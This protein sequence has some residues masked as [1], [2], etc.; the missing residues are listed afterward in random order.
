MLEQYLVV[1]LCASCASAL[2]FFS[3]FG[4]GTLLLPIFALFFPIEVAIA[5]TG[6]VHLLNNLF[7]L[8]L[9][10]RSAV[11]SVV[12]L[13]GL[14]AIAA[15]FGGALLMARLSGLASLFRYTIG[16]TEFVVTPLGLLVGVLM[17]CFALFELNSTAVRAGGGRALLPIGGVLSGFFGGLSGHQGAFRSVFLLRAGLSKEGF[18]ATGIVCAVL[19]DAARLV[20]YGFDA[21]TRWRS[22]QLLL[23]A[24]AVL[25]AFAGAYF[26][27]RVLKKLTIAWLQR[28]VCALLIALGAAIACGWVATR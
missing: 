23:I 2:T 19:V 25:A 13:F 15:S 20:I 14:P 4:L 6:V 18:I 26:G 5:M 27:N 1:A 11:M 17:I 10:G 3:G 22:D 7:K 21:P 24:V 8:A 12:L 9:V 16:D 28:I